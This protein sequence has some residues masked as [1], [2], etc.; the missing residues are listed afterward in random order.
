MPPTTASH[1]LTRMS[2]RAPASGGLRFLGELALAP[3]R[4]HEICGSARR[5][6]A[7]SVARAAA[8]PVFWIRPAWTGE[9]LNG[10]AVADWI[11]PGRL[12]FLAGRRPE[13][14]LWTMEEVLRSGQ[15]PLVVADLPAPPGLTPVRRLHLAAEAGAAAG[16]A[17]LGL[18]LTPGPEGAPGVE[19]RWRLS[20]A[21][22]PEDGVPGSGAW[23]LERLRARSDPPAEWRVA[24]RP[25]SG[26]TLDAPHAP[27]IG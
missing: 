8:G 6:L 16:G 21:H 9:T 13:D 10:V 3:A 22:G 4:V 1:L 25:G 11:D 15:V 12:I 17:P 23:R 18:L 14:L 2:H 24:A 26:M 27:R 7:L 19:T 5:T 20:Q